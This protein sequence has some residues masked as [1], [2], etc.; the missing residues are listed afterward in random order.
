[1]Q[2]WLLP[3][4]PLSSFSD[5]KSVARGF[6]KTAVPYRDYVLYVMD[7]LKLAK[8]TL[9]ADKK[10]GSNEGKT[11]DK[12]NTLKGQNYDLDREMERNLYQLL[13]DDVRYCL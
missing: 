8:G 10:A 2:V 5:T 1:M 3:V 9:I 11:W 7:A 4:E 13:V 6:Y 12:E